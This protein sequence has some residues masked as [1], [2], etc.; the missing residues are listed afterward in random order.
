MN[1]ASPLVLK[2]CGKNQEQGSLLLWREPADVGFCA[3]THNLWIKFAELTFELLEDVDQ[4]VV[5]FLGD[6][7]KRGIPAANSVTYRIGEDQ[8]AAINRGVNEWRPSIMYSNCSVIAAEYGTG[9]LCPVE[10]TVEMHF[11]QTLK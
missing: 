4:R 11:M 8:A 3:N 2:R 6:D 9:I 10:V 7:T 5:V 1:R